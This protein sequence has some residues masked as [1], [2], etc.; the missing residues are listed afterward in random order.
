MKPL[1]IAAFAICAV[2]AL[3]VALGLGEWGAGL[4]VLIAG[5]AFALALDA[6]LGSNGSKAEALSQLRREVRAQRAELDAQRDAMTELASVVEALA[7]AEVPMPLTDALPAEPSPAEPSP[8]EPVPAEPAPEPQPAPPP[9]QDRPTAPEID[10]L[11]ASLRTAPPPP[12]PT[13][14]ASLAERAMAAQDRPAPK[15]S[16]PA[17]TASRPAPRLAPVFEPGG[18]KAAAFVLTMPGGTPAPEAVAKA[19]SIG[20]ELGKAGRSPLLFLRMRAADLSDDDDFEAVMETLEADR[21]F[22]ERLSLLAPQE[23][24]D[25]AG[26][27][28]FTTAADLGASFAL[29]RVRDWSVSLPKLALSGLR[30]VWIDAPSLAQSA[31]Q[32]GGRPDELSSVLSAAGIYMV[33]AGIDRAEDIEDA[34]ALA[35]AL[36]TG[37]ALGATRTLGGEA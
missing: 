37:E 32:Q 6:A 15:P 14:G 36:M 13:R 22:A 34:R 7:E 2:L 17:P 3:V 23:G 25:D 16:A 33:A 28:T 31:A 26:V 20:A 10:A 24:L 19:R 5:A 18:A 21:P 30:H 35:P 4:A 27:Q 1:P 29:E 9:A 12:A 8:A 11:R